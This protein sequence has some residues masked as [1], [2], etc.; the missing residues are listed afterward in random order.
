[1][2]KKG[3]FFL[4]FILLI[5]VVWVIRGESD[6]EIMI[7]FTP[8]QT[9]QLYINALIHG[10]APLYV[11]VGNLVGNV[12]LFIPFGIFL[13]TYFYEVGFLTLL[14]LS[15]YIPFYVEV[16]QFLLY[17]AGYGTRSID[18]DDVLLNMI[19]M[20]IGYLFVVMRRK[21]RP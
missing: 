10:Y 19:G 9:V 4:Y 18:I 21:K 20:I 1:M 8:L 14:F 5:Y 6:P 12:I 13:Y 17:L 2:L 16:V 11:I 3:M 7:N 15:V